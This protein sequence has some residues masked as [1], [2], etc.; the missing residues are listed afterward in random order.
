VNEIELNPQ[1]PHSPEYTLHLGNAF[2]DVVRV[3]NYA[4]FAG[5]DGL[6][7]PADVYALLGSLARGAAGLGQLLTQAGTFLQ[8]QAERGELRISYGPHEGDPEGAVADILPHLERGHAAAAGLVMELG[9]ALNILSAMSW[10]APEE[11]M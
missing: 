2:C 8:R 3:L 5:A 9:K 11:S 6:E 7:Q 4:T 1:G 10:H